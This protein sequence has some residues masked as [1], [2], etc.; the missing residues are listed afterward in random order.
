[1]IAL[2]FIQNI[3]R[4]VLIFLLTKNNTTSSPVF[5]GHR[6]NNLQRAAVLTSL[7]QY[8]KIRFKFNQQQLVMVHYACGCNQSEMGI[9]FD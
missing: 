2:L 6:F 5:L 8:D 7:V 1:M 4:L 3:F 9:Y